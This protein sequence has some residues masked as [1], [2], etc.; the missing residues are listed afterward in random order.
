[1][2]IRRAFAASKP[3]VINLI[4]HPLAGRLHKEDPRLR[5]RYGRNSVGQGAL[6]ARRLVEAGVTFVT[7]HSGG[8]DNHSGIENAMKRHSSNLDPAI[9]SLVSD[10]DQR[11]LL[12]DT[13]VMVMG[14]FGRTPKVNGGAG[15]DHWGN[16]M[17][18]LIGG[19]GLKG[20][21][22]VGESDSKGASPIKRAVKPAHMLHTIYKQF[23]IDPQIT[24]INHSGRPIAILGEGEPIAELL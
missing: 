15:R 21:Q 12:D 11:G 4:T 24:H 18:V 17:S 2:A 7:V 3:A 5:D 22:I 1:M 16:V 20:G 23:G 10:L 6:L 13:I 19:G 8:W 14:E 9:S